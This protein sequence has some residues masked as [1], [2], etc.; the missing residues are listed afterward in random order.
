MPSAHCVYEGHQTQD[1]RKID[2]KYLQSAWGE[3]LFTSMQV[4]VLFVMPILRSRTAR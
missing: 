3:E 4:D 1:K 2:V